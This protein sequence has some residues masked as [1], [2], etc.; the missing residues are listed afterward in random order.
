M[1]EQGT[2]QSDSISAQ[3]E[4]A[5]DIGDKDYGKVRNFSFSR[6]AVSMLYKEIRFRAGYSRNNK[7]SKTMVSG[8]LRVRRDCKSFGKP[9]PNRR[10]GL[11][12]IPSNRFNAA[13]FHSTIRYSPNIQSV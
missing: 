5:L 7:S 3:L 1:D 6:P 2:S 4:E 8:I 11:F 13:K 12:F 10:K 9:E